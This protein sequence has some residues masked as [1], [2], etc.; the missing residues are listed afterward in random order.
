[1]SILFPHRLTHTLFPCSV[2]CPFM[3]TYAGEHW[4]VDTDGTEVEDG[5]SAQH[6]VHGHQIVTDG[7]AEGPHA[8]LELKNRNMLSRLTHTSGRLL[9]QSRGNFTL[10]LHPSHRAL[11]FLYGFYSRYL[12]HILLMLL[13]ESILDKDLYKSSALTGHYS[14]LTAERV[15]CK[16][17]LHTY[18]DILDE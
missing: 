14:L 4:P 16:E 17:A 2:V 18:I 3:C 8:I 1:M 12:K 13:L 9:N 10:F 11:I 6:Y 15:Q 7:G 5:G